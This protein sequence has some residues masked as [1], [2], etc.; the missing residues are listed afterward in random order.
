MIVHFRLFPGKT[1]DSIFS[2]NAK[3]PTILSSIGGKIEFSL[4]IIFF[5]YARQNFLTMHNCTTFKKKL[6]SRLKTTLVLN[7]KSYF[8]N[9]LNTSEFHLF[10]SINTLI[11]AA[12]A[13]VVVSFALF[14]SQ[15][16]YNFD[17]KTLSFVNACL[18]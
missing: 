8:I 10:S 18:L 2:K 3:N 4:C 6:M 7:L 15:V 12:A 13:A 5:L 11:I 1:N 16:F 17:T 9:N 14:V